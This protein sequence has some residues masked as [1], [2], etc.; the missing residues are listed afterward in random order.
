MTYRYLCS[1]FSQTYFINVS[2][3]R[4][5]WWKILER[6]E[7][8]LEAVTIGVGATQRHKRGPN[9]SITC[10]RADSVAGCVAQCACLV[11][12]G[13]LLIHASFFTTEL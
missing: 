12:I 10:E 7:A 13:V 9:L 8:G 3:R 6:Y 5:H 11:T 4:V 1:D 2:I